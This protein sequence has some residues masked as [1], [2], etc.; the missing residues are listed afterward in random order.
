MDV[1]EFHLKNKNW[2]GAEFRFRDALA[3]K[4]ENPQATFKLAQSLDKLGN[5]EGA[6]AE[7]QAY[8][9]MEPEGVFARQAHEALERMK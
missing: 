7:Y 1:G 9:N 4:P 8:L 2:K 6:K 3:V 5:N